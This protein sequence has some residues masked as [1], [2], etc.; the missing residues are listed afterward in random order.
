MMSADPLTLLGAF[1]PEAPEN[2]TPGQLTMQLLDV[3]P[4]VGY[5][6]GGL[7]EK[8]PEKVSENPVVNAAHNLGR[9]FQAGSGAEGVLGGA[10][11][12]VAQAL[13]DLPAASDAM[14]SLMGVKTTNKGM[15]QRLPEFVADEARGMSQEELLQ[16]HG[17]FRD[18]DLQLK[19]EIPDAEMQ[20]TPRMLEATQQAPGSSI[21]TPIP[22]WEAFQHDLLKADAYDMLKDVK[23]YPDAFPFQYD[24]GKRGGFNPA[25]RQLIINL[26]S[27]PE[28]M[29]PGVL[30]EARSTAVH[31]T[32]HAVARSHPNWS[33]GASMDK[34]ESSLR[35]QPERSAALAALDAP[36]RG[37]K[38][39]IKQVM[40]AMREKW[41][42]E[43]EAYRALS[44]PEKA[45]INWAQP[46]LYTSNPTYKQLEQLAR[47]SE[48]KTL[49][50]D[51]TGVLTSAEL[52]RALDVPYKEQIG[53]SFLPYAKALNSWYAAPYAF[54]NPFD[55]YQAKLGEV[56]ARTAEK[57]SIMSPEELM[58]ETFLQTRDKIYPYER[59]IPF[60][61]F[62]RP[63]AVVERARQEDY[64][65]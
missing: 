24:M 55:L 51:P 13:G 15:L 8:A 26:P 39:L 11:S 42:T 46:R 19:Y 45:K 4:A 38:E 22:Y 36:E 6:P 62:S 7:Y 2:M 59:I 33:G 29:N 25:T 61:D 16:K 53:A 40:S 63:R 12:V 37:Y 65:D 58:A 64:G 57:R 3:N 43:F 44:A 31:E 54:D 48:F 30:T 27:Q 34:V 23:V 56:N 41:N 35:N 10:G 14:G 1:L 60:Y 49:R 20:F 17:W 47:L 32:D 9:M 50:T 52:I 28:Q 18:K 21:S 5:G